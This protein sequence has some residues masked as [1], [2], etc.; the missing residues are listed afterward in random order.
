MVG[1]QQVGR[2]DDG[3]EH[4][5]E[6]M[7]DAAGQLPDGLHLLALRHLDLE[8]LLLG[9]LD[10]VDDRR[11]LGAFAAGA[12]GD[13]I[14]VE[15][16]V[17]LVIVGQHR[18]ERRDIG[19]PL[20]GLFEGRGKRS[21]VAF[22]NDP[23]EADTAVDGIAVDH[24]REQRQ[25]RR[26]GTHDA[27]ALVDAG[28]RHRR[29]VEEA[30]EPDLGRPQL[31]RSVLAEIAVEHDRAARTGRALSGCGNPV[32][33]AHRQRLAGGSRKVEIDDGVARRARI[34]PDRAYQ[35]HAVAGDDFRK[36]GIAGR[37][38][39]K[40]DA[41]PFGERGVDVGDAAFLVGGEEAGRRVV[42]MVDRLLQVEEEAFLLGP[43]A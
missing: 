17:P 12:V 9:R 40:I 5:V 13:C 32:H 26:V 38:A 15:A 2:H 33:E 1:E 23:V 41:Q 19:L 18:V 39:R 4:V 27:A 30:R 16:D 35:R 11:L 10:G 24:R 22:V 42:E 3:G 6:I 43:L 37:E 7:C 36:G 21:A 8:R 20:L 14:D 28:D 29:R 34:G 31:C 25:E